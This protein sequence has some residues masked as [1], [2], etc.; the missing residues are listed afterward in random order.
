MV[1]EDLRH[2]KKEIKEE[3][4]FLSKFF[5]HLTTLKE[6]GIALFRSKEK[7]ESISD[8]IN[9]YEKKE[10]ELRQII[11][12]ISLRAKKLRAR[13]NKIMKEYNR[14]T[15][16]IIKMLKEDM[17]KRPGEIPVE[18]AEL[19]QEIK[20]LDNEKAEVMENLHYFVANHERLDKLEHKFKEIIRDK[21]RLLEELEH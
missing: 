3:E 21:S 16:K 4:T 9:S 13:Q 19:A 7:K 11:S 20:K 6:Q 1:R 5:R 14:E 12:S 10:K 18:I 15:E 8:L 17:L 2:I